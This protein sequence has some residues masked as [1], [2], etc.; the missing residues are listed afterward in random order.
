MTGF[1]NTLKLRFEARVG[2]DE[3]YAN[4][5]TVWYNA[6]IRD[7]VTDILLYN[8]MALFTSMAHKKF[9]LEQHHQKIL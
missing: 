2:K 5:E 6:C 1:I 3:A 8:D 7:T 9:I 4:L